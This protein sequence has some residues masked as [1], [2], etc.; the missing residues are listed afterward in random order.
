[1]A[2][3]PS[4]TGGKAGPGQS[5]E[6]HPDEYHRVLVEQAADGI[7][8]A[9]DEG[10][11]VDVNASG[12]RLLGYEVG[13]LIGKRIAD[14]VRSE[15]RTHL[16]S[17]SETAG[18]T[19]T[20]E[21]VMVRRDGSLLDVE[22]TAQ[23]LS[24]G[25]LLGIVRDIALRKESERKTR[26]YAAQLRSVLE[27]APDVIMTADRDGKIL[28]INRSPSTR[29]STQIV[30]TN[31]IEW[32]PAPARGR[33]RAAIDG[34][35]ATRELDEYEVEGPVTPAG[36]RRWWSVRVGPVVEGDEV[37]AVTLCA[38]DV[39]ERKNDELRR[40]ELLER[41]EKIARH[42]PG[43]VYQFKMRPDGTFC[44]PYV[45][46]RIREI[47]RVDP[48][49]V[50]EDASKAFDLIHP[51]DVPG[52]LES[53]TASAATMEPWRHE[54]RVRFPAGEVRWMLG[55]SRPERQDDGSVLWHGFVTDVTREKDAAQKSH[56]LEDQLRQSQK[57]ESIGR[58]AGGVAHDFN[59]LLTS[60]LGFTHLAMDEVPGESEA[61]KH[62]ACVVE[63]AERGAAL[64][65]QL[66]AFARKK[67]VKPEVVDPNV[68]LRRM[69]ALLRRLVG[70][71]AELVLDLAPETGPVRI[72]VGGMEQVLM[73]LVVNARDAV[74]GGGRIKLTTRNEHLGADACRAL[75]G[76]AP[77]IHVCVRVEDTGVGMPPE[78]QARL[79]EPFFTTKEIGEGS[80]LGLA[81]CHGIVKQ[82]S[83][84]IAVRSQL[85]AG[86]S[87]SVY[88][89][90][91]REPLTPR[92]PTPTEGASVGGNETVL[93]VE[94]EDLILKVA[95]RT[96]SSLGY[97]VLVAPD[98]T[99]AL[100]LAAATFDPIHLL[101][102]DVIM[103]RVSGREL[104]TRL[105]ALRPGIR[106]LFS[107]GYSGDV[108]T[109]K[110]V[111]VEGLHFLQ[112]PYT[113]GTLAKRVR[114]VLDS[115]A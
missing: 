27:T 33:V 100:E 82:A 71:D 66:L 61:A 86:S 8:I 4:M 80:G 43:V 87:F 54:Y 74:R 31:C 6:S 24:S 60:V 36:V 88:L 55:N 52:I 22:I 15:E 25:L 104:A 67:I 42:V 96:L 39:T 38:T 62:L 32:V 28:F 2:A 13:E 79:F 64:T 97:R 30:G 45:S 94:D 16:T 72:D 108:L 59:N 26:A 69:T 1:M 41:L 76:L 37:V 14:V 89:P 35:F 65:Q 46:E 98:A 50:R 90:L 111:L 105:Q 109:D 7:F 63:S 51:D 83:G 53:I 57:V 18:D 9:N 101:V 47:Y 48:D 49:D 84:H 19:E 115:P 81:M 29:T 112:K 3:W 21:R 11:Y 93:L 92:N 12:H 77:G 114:E 106:V 10:V 23:K 34:V 44:F 68:I 58:L 40:R 70:E 75:G 102:T 5:W 56:E 113:L 103:P 99:H 110:G 17:A 91:V 107:S 20:R 78:V 73:N 85:G 95:R